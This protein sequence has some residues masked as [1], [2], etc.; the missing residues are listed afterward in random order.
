MRKRALLIGVNQYHLLG[1]LAYARQDAEAV[2]DTLCRNCGF[3][4]QDIT[5]MTCQSEGACMGLS[6][7]IE[8]ALLNLTAAI[9]HDILDFYARELVPFGKGQEQPWQPQMSA[10]T[11]FV[12]I[13][14]ELANGNFGCQNHIMNGF[15][16]VDLVV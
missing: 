16:R 15:Q 8:H 13:R 11:R 10:C 1:N 4:D 7:Y 14:Q 5:L 6:R 3:S 9:G 12:S 2:A